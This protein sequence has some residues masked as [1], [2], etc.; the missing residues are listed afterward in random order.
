LAGIILKDKLRVA[1]EQPFAMPVLQAS[2]MPLDIWFG[3]ECCDF[4][5]A[6]TQLIAFFIRP[7]ERK[8]TDVTS[9]VQ[10]HSVYPVLLK[11]LPRFSQLRTG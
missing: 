1:T 3:N 10:Q 2:I 8:K 5:Q 4:Q 6:F 7:L 9:D 11:S